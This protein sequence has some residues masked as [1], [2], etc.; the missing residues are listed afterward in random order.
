MRFPILVPLRFAFVSFVTAALAAPAALFGASR[1]LF[2][3]RAGGS[4]VRDAEGRVVASLL[5]GQACASSRFFWSR[6]SI[7]DANPALSGAS[8]ASID[9]DALKE[10]VQ[11]ALARAALPGLQGWP[12]MELLLSS[13]SGLDPHI[14]LEAALYQVPRV[15]QARRLHPDELARLAW[16]LSAPLAPFSRTRLVNVVRLNLA[17]ETGR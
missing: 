17:L 1:L 13:A 14:S 11:S 6:P 12:P 8:N 4:L 16:D 2:P 5:L 10:R 7:I 15:A 9:S 3:E